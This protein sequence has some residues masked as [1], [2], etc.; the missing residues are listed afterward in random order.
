MKHSGMIRI[1]SAEPL[2]DFVVRLEFTDGTVSE[3]DLRPLIRGPVFEPHRRDPDFFRSMYVDRISGT[4][5][6]PNDTDLDP[7]VLYARATGTYDE[8]MGEETASG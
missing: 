3:I 6:W 4:I 5:A 7:D 2:H 1:R 8:L